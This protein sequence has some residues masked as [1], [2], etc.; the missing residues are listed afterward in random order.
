[1]NKM[2][3]L[4]KLACWVG[5]C[6][7]AGY[8]SY[9]TAKSVAMSFELNNQIIAVFIFVFIVALLAGWCLSITIEELQNRFNP[10]KTRFIGGILGFLLFWGVSFATNVHYMLMSK[11]GLRVVTAELGVYKTYV[12]DYI[13]NS[14]TGIH[15]QEQADIALCEASVQNL[16][17][18]FKRE[19][20]SSV[21]YGFGDR[22]IGYL[23]DIEDYFTSSGGK[24][25]DQYSYKR[26]IFDD[27]KDRGDKGKTGARDVMALKEK[28]SIRIAEKLLRR[29]TVIKNFYKQ[30]QS[31]SKNMDLMAHFINDSLYTIDVP[32]ITEIA[33][34][35]VYYQFQKIQLQGNIFNRLDNIDQVNILNSMKESKTGN[36]EDIEKGEY[37]YRV[38]PSSRMFGT[39]NVWGDMLNGRLPADM[40]LI[41]WILFS[42]IVDLVAF[43]LRILAK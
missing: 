19:C 16:M 25:N 35:D 36:V 13:R 1:M 23:K 12:E 40:K 15:E 42:L 24:F 43:I 29:E 32:Q 31:Q 8:S 28:Y 11:D 26:S 33:T 5:Y 39:F 20:E 9:M 21:R 7:F 22:A 27:D 6:L 37:R 10:S 38:Y 41:G 2:K 14:R 3:L 4:K 17:D 34:P 30:K 18:E